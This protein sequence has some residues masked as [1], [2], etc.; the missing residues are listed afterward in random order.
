[1]SPSSGSP[2]PPELDQLPGEIE[3]EV[4][5]NVLAQRVGLGCV[6]DLSLPDSLLDHIVDRVVRSSFEERYRVVVPDDSAAASSQPVPPA[7]SA[8]SSWVSPAPGCTPVSI[9]RLSESDIPEPMRAV[10]EARPGCRAF[11]SEVA[12]GRSERCPVAPDTVPEDPAERA[13]AGQVSAELARAG[14]VA[15]VCRAVRSLGPSGFAHAGEAELARLAS[16]GLPIDLLRHFHGESP[17]AEPSAAGV[18]RRIAAELLRNPE[19]L[20]HDLRFSFRR[21]SATFDPGDDSAPA[22]PELLRAQMTRGG[23]WFGPGSG[24]NLDLIRRVADALPDVPLLVTIESVY[25]AEFASCVRSW[26]RAAPVTILSVPA[27]VSQWAQDN[28]RAGVVARDDDSGGQ[29]GAVR[30][31]VLAPRYPS[32]GDD[33]SVLVPGEAVAVRALERVELPVIPSPLLFQ[34]GNLIVCA[35]P[36]DL[37]RRLLLTGEAEVARNVSLGLSPQ[38]ATEAL[39]GEFGV[40]RVVVLPAVSYHIDYEVSVRRQGAA[41]VALVVDERAGVRMVLSCALDVIERARLLPKPRLRAARQYLA[42]SRWIELL[43]MFFGAVLSQA[44]GRHGQIV[45]SFVRHFSNG[46]ADHGVSNLHRVLLAL[47]TMT[48]W[49]HAPWEPSLSPHARAY[50]RAIRRRD[51]SRARLW[52]I[53][54]EAGFTVAPIPGLSDADRSLCPVNGIQMAGTYFLPVAAGGG[55]MFDPL[56]RACREA[57]SAAL[58]PD[59]ETAPIPS[60]ESQNRNGAVHCSVSVH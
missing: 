44:V 15:C 37:A 28:A 10:C 35:D 55:S 31:A 51:A 14:L 24:D 19:Y 20:G 7:A 23:H 8:D 9:V 42:A 59:V 38:Q 50:L 25:E 45:E 17:P 12:A 3:A 58:G 41:V 36:R 33:G 48:S 11:W 39:R 40:D 46:P 54:R 22:P 57:L 52:S 53:L 4:R 60:L 29:T 26:T 1:M 32:R 34:G 16:L 56:I 49:V 30:R 18:V 13:V 43:D 5:A 27:T 6:A 47:D 2:L 21:T